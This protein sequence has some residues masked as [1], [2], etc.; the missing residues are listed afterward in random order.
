MQGTAGR[1]VR[2]RAFAGSPRTLCPCSAQPQP[3]VAQE[4]PRCPQPAAAPQHPATDC[5]KRHTQPHS[6]TIVPPES[7]LSGSGPAKLY[8]LSTPASQE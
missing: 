1:G 7:P 4:V 2:S 6:G 8:Q 3:A 5:S